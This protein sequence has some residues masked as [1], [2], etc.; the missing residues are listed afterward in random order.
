MIAR[1]FLAAMVLGGLCACS[2]GPWGTVAASPKHAAATLGPAGN[3]QQRLDF[4]RRHAVP[5]DPAGPLPA[6]VMAR[7][8]P[9]RTVLL[10]ELHGTAEIP[11]LALQIARA[12]GAAGRQVILG[13]EIPANE[14]AIVDRYRHS[15]DPALL[16]Q[17]RFFGRPIQDGRSSQA[18]AKLIRDSAGIPGLT[19]ICIDP[20]SITSP[21]DRDTG[22]AR[23][24]AAALKARPDATLV[25][26]T[27][28]VH[29]RLSAGTRWDPAYRPMGYELTHHP[30][31]PFAG[32]A[33]LAAN[34][35]SLA[36]TAWNCLEDGC[37]IQPLVSFP[38]VYARALPGQDYFVTEPDLQEGHNGAFVLQGVTAS[39]PLGS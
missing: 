39:L 31:F 37:G 35:H 20:V 17:S 18:M 7:L 25:T 5:I 3:D 16:R 36:G 27:G 1:Q 13:L 23:R 14:Q 33:I 15:G 32:D 9:Y 29:S 38:S 4:I 21:Q 26:L 22:M 11:A 6:A 12:F 30:E 19:V 10:G 24:L 28:N 8:Q 2:T 34:V